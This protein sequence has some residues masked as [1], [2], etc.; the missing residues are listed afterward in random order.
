MNK[1]TKLSKILDGLVSK[2]ASND[3][4]LPKVLDL[5]TE[6]D[7]DHKDIITWAQKFGVQIAKGTKRKTKSK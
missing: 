5:I 2:S 7:Q 1:V 4:H 3:S 6:L